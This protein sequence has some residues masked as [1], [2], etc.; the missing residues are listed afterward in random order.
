MYNGKQGEQQL[1]IGS[2][3][4]KTCP[5]SCRNFI[6]CKIS[7][8]SL[9]CCF[10]YY[11]FCLKH[12]LWVHVRTASEYT[13]ESPL[14]NPHFVFIKVGLKGVLIAW[15]CFYD[16]KKLKAI[17]PLVFVQ[18]WHSVP[19]SEVNEDLYLANLANCPYKSFIFINSTPF[20]LTSSI[21]LHAIAHL[22]IC[23]SK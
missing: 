17:V 23:F 16:D 22:N 2:I 7:K 10:Y 20:Y 9:E 3:I 14:H 19:R 8:I 12:R 11:Y 6:G 1:K 21:M 15:T 13:F 4:R 18:V 5:C